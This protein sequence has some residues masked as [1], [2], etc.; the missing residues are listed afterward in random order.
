MTPANPRE[1]MDEAL[2]HARRLSKVLGM[3]SPDAL[4]IAV[5]GVTHHYRRDAARSA[6][7]RIILDLEAVKTK[8]GAS[9]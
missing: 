5:N 8:E 7:A 1:L 3:M 6:V 2:L 9:T 4:G